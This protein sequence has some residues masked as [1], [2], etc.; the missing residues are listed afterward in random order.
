MQLSLGLSLIAGFF[1]SNSCCL[2][3]ASF[4]DSNTAVI[5][6]NENAT[7]E[8]ATPLLVG[9]KRKK[10][11]INGTSKSIQTVTPKVV[12][13]VPAAKG[14]FKVRPAGDLDN[15][16]K[17]SNTNP[18]IY[19]Y[20]CFIPF[21]LFEQFFGWLNGCA[22]SLVAPNVVLC[23]AHCAGVSD[24]V[25]LGMYKIKLDAGEA[26][27]FY[28]IEHIPIAEAIVHP[29]YNDNTLNN[30]YLIIRLQWASTLYSGN[31][32]S[33][34]TPSDD[35][36]LGNTSGRELV[37]MG[38]GTLAYGWITPNIMQKVNLEYLS[39]ADCVSPK[40]A[41]DPS[42]ITSSMLCAALP[43]KD[44]CQVSSFV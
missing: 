35:L 15:M 8:D 39:N 22:A 6:D 17:L 4:F 5:L 36:V 19:F 30:D 27:E 11:S 9:G 33:L 10:Q 43:G 24:I 38:F 23:A 25:T 14:E 2:A 13:G 12:G 31:V 7:D 16:T 32:V 29:D 20:S 28:N 44:T 41:Y 1:L 21:V 26:A 34:D 3:T 42:E 37:V 18:F 40:N